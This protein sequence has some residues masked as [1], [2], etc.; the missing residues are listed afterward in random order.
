MHMGKSQNEPRPAVKAVRC[1]QAVAIKFKLPSKS[2]AMRLHGAGLLSN[3]ALTQLFAT[4]PH[5]R[6]A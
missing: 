6:N 1:F 5:W 2:Q 4:R 3:N